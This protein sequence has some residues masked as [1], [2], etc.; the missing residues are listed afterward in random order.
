[1]LTESLLD[2]LR[3]NAPAR[4]VQVSSLGQAPIDFDDPML[5]GAYDRA[6][7]PTASRSSPR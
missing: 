7:A 4:V 1:M 5:T 6:A 3:R 2:L